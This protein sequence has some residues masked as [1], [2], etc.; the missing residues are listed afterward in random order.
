MFRTDLLNVLNTRRAWA[1]LG[2]GTSVG[3]GLPTWRGLLKGVVDS[4]EPDDRAR[5]GRD[6]R[7]KAALAKSDYPA[8]F[9]RVEACLGR[10]VME[11]KVRSQI[12][13]P[14][15]R[16]T[17]LRELVDWPFAGY[18][19]TNY[20]DLIER[21]LQDAGHAGWVGIG[22]TEPE[23]PK[24][25]G[26]VSK[27]VWHIH[28]SVALPSQR[29]RLVLT[30]ADY[31]EIYLEDSAVL[32]QLRAVLS[33]RR[34]VIVGFGLADIEFM[35][36]LR[37]VG[38]LSNPAQP[39]FALVP[40]LEGIGG[41]AQRM[42]LLE[43]YNIDVVPYRDPDNSHR[44]L[45]DLV[46]TYGSMTLRRS[47]EFGKPARD[48]PSYDPETTGLLL[49]NELALKRT[50]TTSDDV[51]DVLVRAMLL[52]ELA[53]VP[54]TTVLNLFQAIG[55]RTRVLQADSDDAMRLLDRALTSLIEDQLVE[56]LGDDR[57]RLTESGRTMVIR[58]RASS[59]LRAQQFSAALL[60]RA[61]STCPDPSTAARV[62]TA[63]ESFLKKCIDDRALGLAMASASTRRKE[64][65][66]H[67]VALFQSLPEFMEQLQDD[68][69]ALALTR[70]VTALLANPD[71]V[72]KH[73]IG[74]SI[75]AR[76]G[77]HLLGQDP[78]GLRARIADFE[79]ATFL[80]DASVLIQVLARS[81]EPHPA[82]KALLGR[83]QDSGAFIGTTERL[84]EEVA[85]HA[86]WALR[87]VDRSSGQ[88][89]TR[90][91]EAATGRAG[92]WMNAFLEGFLA[93]AGRGDIRP[94]IKGYLEE[95]L[96]KPTGT[97]SFGLPEVADALGREAVPVVAFEA[98][99]GFS[100]ELLV[101]RDDEESKIREI[102]TRR[103]NYKH[104]RQV[105]AEAEALLIVQGLRNGDLSADGKSASTAFFV[106]HTRL[107]DR[108]DNS[109]PP[110]TMHPNLLL[111]WLI[112]L[113]PLPDAELSVLTSAL[114]WELEERGLAIVDPNRL[115]VTFGSLI[116]ASQA[117]LPDEVQRYRELVGDRFGEP[118][119]RAFADVSDL[120]APIVLES[121]LVQRATELD[122]RMRV[123]TERSQAAKLNDR[124]MKELQRLR[125]E[126][127]Q[128]TLAAKSRA[129]STRQ[130]THRKGR[131][132]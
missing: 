73:Y 34:L 127:K 81:S 125:A 3:A 42:E 46:K 57:F 36:V 101:E 130:R 63:A 126:K 18:I 28:G 122:L 8:C 24:L 23:L 40:D 82:A 6:P 44:Q 2:S 89:T 96:S 29:S 104:D 87:Q 93:E 52:A 100:S 75:Q 62:A 71:D 41:T 132:K 1:L 124:D 117:Q 37:R 55:P 39:V 112:T 129:R 60:A 4:L 19:T 58:R 119:A 22:N 77:T 108:L 66:F 49:Y 56:R 65:K 97:R 91:L 94:T 54:T 15:R 78:S 67:M 85:E 53:Q 68:T 116:D 20:D 120:D 64:N 92:D 106:S 98:W 88:V 21:Y 9:S 30:G 131:R 7:F 121:L 123:L 61:T 32:H 118:A 86:R 109:G 113:H 105:R 102:R 103:G 83:L 90:T 114:L 31:D 76:F 115:R 50:S 69:E 99:D 10:D 80:M 33:T 59:E 79:S 110:I 51:L 11:G 111:Q 70:V 48:C 43:K 25:S 13:T 72:E 95:V 16:S 5:L 38:L 17:L 47:L 14:S 27:L 26:D 84:A 12:G 128:R 45:L 35:R 74:L 107:L